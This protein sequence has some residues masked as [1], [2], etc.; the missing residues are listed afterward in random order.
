MP[1]ATRKST[2][3]GPALS[4]GVITGTLS[5]R[6][7]LCPVCERGGQ[8][9]V[10]ITRIQLPDGIEPSNHII[11]YG[12]YKTLKVEPPKAIGLTCGC[13]ARFHRQVAKIKTLREV[14]GK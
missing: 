10:L 12:M 11:G 13:Y 7:R 6:A 2:T 8:R 3:P 4:D 9:V 1:P 14:G 5:P